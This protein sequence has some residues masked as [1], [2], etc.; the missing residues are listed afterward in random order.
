MN[1]H[2]EILIPK[3]RVRLLDANLL[4]NHILDNSTI[5]VEDVM[6]IKAIN[7][8]LTN[9]KPYAAILSFGF[10]TEVTQKSRE[11][12]A[13]KDFQQNTI[14]KALLVN[15]FGHRLLGNFYLTV[16]KPHIRTRLFTDR[17]LALNWLRSELSKALEK[18]NI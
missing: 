3:C 9:G 15:N 13:S 4:E 7:M 2:A 18:G 5:E 16:N 1:N 6:E 12:L 11:L 14:A 17:E 8:Q 10:M